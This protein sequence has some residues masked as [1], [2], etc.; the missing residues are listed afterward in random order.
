[1]AIRSR[2]V[3]TIADVARACGVGTMTVSRVI[4][5]KKHVSPEMVQRVEEAIAR[6]NYQPNEAARTLKGRTSRTI[7]LIVP[8]LSDPFF[9]QCAHAVQQVA[10]EQGYMTMLFACEANRN[11]EAEELSQMRS[12]NIAGILIVPS[13]ENSLE[14]LQELRR[15]GMPVV[16]IDRTFAGIDV[17]EVMVENIE[18]ALRA[19][20]HLIDHGHQRILCVGYDREY[21]SISQRIDGFKKAVQNASLQPQYLLVNRGVAIGPRVIAALRSPKPPTAIFTLNNVTS[22]AVLTALKREEIRIPQQV[23]IIG[24][25]DFDLASLLA[26]P[27]TAVRQPAA[28]L[29][30]HA[31]R[32]LIDSLRVGNGTGRMP[33]RIVLPTELIVRQS[34]GCEPISRIPHSK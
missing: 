3:V 34:C 14:Q 4:N 12:R 7:G 33:S 13:S 6:L 26:V 1:M 16:M 2:S 18:G 32:M 31:T 19:T 5:G 15:N 24:F 29:G 21:N 22:V 30:R 25:D 17:G 9:S 11:V 10:A 20:N 27:L 8:S 23:A 28:E